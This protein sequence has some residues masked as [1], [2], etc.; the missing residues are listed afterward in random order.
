MQCYTTVTAGVTPESVELVDQT[1]RL[2]LSHTHTRTHVNIS[3]RGQA[4]LHF[5]LPAEEMALHFQKGLTHVGM[6][7]KCA[8]QSYGSP[9]GWD[10]YNLSFSRNDPRSTS[11]CLLFSK[12]LQHFRSEQAEHATSPVL[13]VVMCWC[14]EQSYWEHTG[15][16]GLQISASVSFGG[17]TYFLDISQPAWLS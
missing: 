12:M 3:V 17:G 4:H 6:H 2:A 15:I 1:C 8:L 5:S 10:F 14:P 13:V 9:S 7:V 11:H 16:L